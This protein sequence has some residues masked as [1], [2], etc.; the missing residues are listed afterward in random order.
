MFTLG[1][2]AGLVRLGRAEMVLL[3]NAL[4]ALAVT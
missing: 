2:V 3:R 1:R 4:E